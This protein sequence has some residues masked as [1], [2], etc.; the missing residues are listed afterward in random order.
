MGSINQKENDMTRN[1]NWFHKPAHE[2]GSTHVADNARDEQEF[3]GQHSTKGGPEYRAAMRER[4]AA[5]MGFL[6]PNAH[7]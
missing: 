4:Q 5:K 7:T 2:L 3:I 6:L 1:Y